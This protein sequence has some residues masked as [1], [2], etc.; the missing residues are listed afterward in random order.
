MSKRGYKAEKPGASVRQQLSSE[1]MRCLPSDVRPHG[2]PLFL[3]MER[4]DSQAAIVRCALIRRRAAR[5]IIVARAVSIVSQELLAPV[6]ATL[7]RHSRHRR[8]HPTGVSV[9]R[10]IR[11]GS[12]IERD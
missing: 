4:H 1:H 2:K 3:L 10:V 6:A 5:L 9:M 8:C 12:T 11:A 7:V